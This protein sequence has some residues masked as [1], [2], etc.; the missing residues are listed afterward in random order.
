MRRALKRVLTPPLLALAALV[1]AAEE[2]LWRLAKVYAW[3][4]RLP[5]FRA[6]ER[7]ASSLPP[8]GALCLFAVPSVTLA[9]V[10]FLALYWMAGG[11]PVL[12]AGTIVTAKIAGTALVARIYQLT[13]PALVTLGWFAWGEAKVLG[14]RAAAYRVWRES[15][16]GRW[17]MTRVRRWREQF[18]RWRERRRSWI[19]MRWRAIR[20]HRKKGGLAAEESGGD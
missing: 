5:V 13:R 1:I 6:V 8:Y 14:V 19:A 12:G 11:H 20:E 4:G 15:A 3:L 2:I 17:T 10:K 18:R 7:W 9:P 16:L